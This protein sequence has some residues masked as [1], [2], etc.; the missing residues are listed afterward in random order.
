MS[1]PP[2]GQ[3]PGA[4][5]DSLLRARGLPRPMAMKGRATFD[6][7]QYRVRGRFEL[8]LDAAAGAV[9]EFSGSTLLGGHREDIVASLAGD[10]L[11]I[12]DRERG[13]FYEG[14]GVDDFIRE[15][16]RAAGDW[17]RAVRRILAE[18][19]VGPVDRAEFRSDDVRGRLA[20]GEFRLRWERGRLVEADW[21]DPAPGETFA[22]RLEV[23]YRWEGEV[24]VRL[25]ARLPGR[26]WRFQLEAD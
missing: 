2:A 21:P 22:D 24:P 20:D 8:R 5:V 4:A 1:E 6:V 16:T 23:R 12:L 25:E 15:E 17:S 10:T 11:R 9:L 3:S 13:R 26:G 19:G 14:A 7:E 18:P